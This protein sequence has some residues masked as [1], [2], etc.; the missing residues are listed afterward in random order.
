MKKVLVLALA[1]MLALSG[2]VVS[3]AALSAPGEMPIVAGDG[4]VTLR[5]LVTEH[6][7]I[8]DWSTNEFIKWMETQTNVKIEFE[9]VPLEGREE[10]VNLVLA[11]GNYP[12]VFFGLNFTDAQIQQYGMEEKLLMPL[13]DLIKDN[14]PNTQKI[15]EQYPGAE[16][17]ITQLDGNIYSLPNVNECYHCNVSTKMWINQKWL[18]N[19]GL[20][21]PTTTDELYNVLKAFK[22]Q[23]ANGNGDVNDELP[24]AG[25]HMDGWNNN[26]DR[27]I[28][29]SFL[30]YDMTL[31]SKTS[32][33]LYV[34]NDVVKLPYAEEAMKDGLR[35]MRKL[36]DEGLYYDGSFNQTAV[37]L[38]QL[39]ENVD[40][41]LVGVVPS[42]YGG[43]F[44]QLGGERYQE[45]RAMLPLKGPD[46]FQT[47]VLDPYGSVWG[48]NFLLSANAAN[49]EAAI[50]WGDFIYTFEATSRAYYGQ[51]DV[52]WRE[53]T[54]GE[55]GINGLPALYTQLLPWQETDPQN[56]HIVQQGI[57]FRDSAYRLG[58]TFDQ[59]TD[60]YSADG[61]EKLLYEV[62]KEYTPFGKPEMKIPPVKFTKAE[63]D[64][65]M[66]I[67][68][69]LNNAIRE[70]LTA[71]MTGAKDVDADYD[72][73]LADLD[74]KGAKTLVEYYQKAYD[75]QFKK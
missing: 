62:S 36:Y 73:F 56:E 22:E 59:N 65:M 41:N 63:N 35:Y 33:G 25:A 69:E 60:L 20:S 64:E 31:T 71:F 75:A 1:L 23:D 34:E 6:P 58:M 19:L 18:D 12:D 2:G 13:N 57:D 54:E 17:M 16:A 7:A 11:S 55:I 47:T 10:K 50:K 9:G 67:K 53:A 21:M 43:M 30:Y 39:V 5:F 32:Y 61:L 8:I 45:Y 15:F 66:V 74:A 38:T 37:Q 68:T 27:F 42:G 46:G 51:K 28:L 14:A 29:N 44:S 48:R 40:A 3:A 4:D 24:M 26:A 49:P 72:A 52:A 70:G